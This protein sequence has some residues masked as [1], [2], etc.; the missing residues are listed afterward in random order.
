MIQDA[1]EI[2]TAHQDYGIGAWRRAP[3]LRSLYPFIAM[4]VFS[5]YASKQ[6]KNKRV[7]L[8]ELMLMLFRLT[9]LCFT[10]P[11]LFIHWKFLQFRKRCPCHSFSCVDIFGMVHKQ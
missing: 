6:H 8:V 10:W 2:L 9:F 1:R 11:L 4:S 5:E 3:S 7:S